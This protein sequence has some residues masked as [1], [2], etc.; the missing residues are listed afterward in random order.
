MRGLPLDLW[1]PWERLVDLFFPKDCRN[2]GD[3]FSAGLSNILCRA[4]FGAIE[5][6]QLPCCSHCGLSLAPGAFE[7]TVQHRCAECGDGEF[8]L[9]EVR[10]FGAYEGSLRIAH[11]GFKFEGLEGLARELGRGMAGLL[12]PELRQD[13]VLV[14]VP[15]RPEKERERGYNPAFLLAR[16][17]S[18]HWGIG[19]K[20]LLRKT[21]NTPPQMSLSQKER[22][23]NPVGAYAYHPVGPTPPTAILVDDVYTTG[24]TLE[25]C[26]KV[27]KK[28][29][30]PTV[31][32]VTWGRT[33]KRN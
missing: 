9:D 10:A 1:R 29:G 31:H 24:S 18:T 25:E 15:M 30:I 7:G 6:Y 27:L 4:C 19:S 22:A 12:G 2:C 21:R 3:P 32:A 23:R 33:A 8:F 20:P 16:E 17:L 26:A 11:H 13:A 14:P 5:P 28:A